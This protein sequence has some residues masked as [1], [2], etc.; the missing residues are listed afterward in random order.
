LA[1]TSVSVVGD[2]LLLFPYGSTLLGPGFVYLFPKHFVSLF[3]GFRSFCPK[4]F[5]LLKRPD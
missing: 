5:D 3:F 2:V 1:L 4:S